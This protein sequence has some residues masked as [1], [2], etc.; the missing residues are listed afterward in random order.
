MIMMTMMIWKN[1]KQRPQK[2]NWNQR[3]PRFGTTAMK[4][5]LHN[6]INNNNFWRRRRRRRRRNKYNYN[7]ITNKMKMK[8]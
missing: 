3:T 1:R 4:K 7:T 6:T 8:K 2:R 5:N